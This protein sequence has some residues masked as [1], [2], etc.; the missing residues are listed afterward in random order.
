MKGLK[1]NEAVLGV[2]H[3]K[4]AISYGNIG[5]V[6]DSKGD[7]STALEYLLKGLNIME[8]VLGV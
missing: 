8:A 2:E 4:T 6:Y 1:I 3:K 7:Y 5:S